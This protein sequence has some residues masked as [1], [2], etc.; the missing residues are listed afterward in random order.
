MVDVGLAFNHIG[1]YVAAKLNDIDASR[2]ELF[3][4]KPGLDKA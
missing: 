3:V 4:F 1:I 2:I